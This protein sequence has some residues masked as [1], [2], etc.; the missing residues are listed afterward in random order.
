MG[1]PM[2]INIDDCDTPM[3]SIDD[4]VGELTGIPA[5]VK[6]QYLPADVI[7]LARYWVSLLKLSEALGGVLATHY[8]PPSKGKPL[9]SDI[10]ANEK[11]ILQCAQGCRHEGEFPSQVVELHLYQLQ[12][13]YE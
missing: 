5:S 9:P 3:P 1:R 8:R 2:R 11:E 7:L 13:Y 10:E 12:L 6:D 4:F